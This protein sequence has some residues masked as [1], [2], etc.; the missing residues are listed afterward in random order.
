[1][2]YGAKIDANQPEIVAALRKAGC[3]VQHLHAVG[4]GCPDLLC[5]VQG[6]TF[7]IE[8]KDGSKPPSKQALTSDQAT[9]HKDWG[10]Q[11]HVV[12]SVAGALAVAEM[13]KLRALKEE[14]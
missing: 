14:A 5:A 11:V 13:Y 6:E 2:R 10:A 8:V 3:T 9:W 1:M 4:K 12:N 7:L